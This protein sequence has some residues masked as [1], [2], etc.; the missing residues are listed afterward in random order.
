[1]TADLNFF[2]NAEKSVCA[3][4][5][6]NSNRTKIPASQARLRTPRI[7]IGDFIISIPRSALFQHGAQGNSSE[8][9]PRLTYNDPCGS[10]LPS[11]GTWVPFQI[12]YMVCQLLRFVLRF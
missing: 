10:N 8:Q 6:G 12:A 7:T 5:F 4:A 9:S 3:N 1:M 11:P 2:Q